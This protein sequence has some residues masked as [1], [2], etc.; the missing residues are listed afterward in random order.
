[1]MRN[2]RRSFERVAKIALCTIILASTSIIHTAKAGNDDA[3]YT[4][5]ALDCISSMN[6]EV[7]IMIYLIYDANETRLSQAISTNTTTLHRAAKSSPC[8]ANRWGGGLW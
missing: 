6:Y 1:M 2:F 8:T 7:N 4:H 5:N 3:I